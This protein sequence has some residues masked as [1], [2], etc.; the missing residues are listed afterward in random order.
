VQQ[1]DGDL[2]TLDIV[3]LC[4]DR[5]TGDDQGNR[6]GILC[7]WHDQH[8]TGDEGTSVWVAA[9]GR[10]PAFKCL[11]AH[12]QGRSLRDLLE[13]YGKEAVDAHCAEQFGD[14]S[15][16]LDERVN[17]IYSDYWA[18]H[19]RKPIEQKPRGDGR[20][21]YRASELRLL[22]KLDW[23]IERHYQTGGYCCIYG[24]PSSC[25]SFIALDQA[26]SIATGTP[27]LGKW[28]VRQAPVVYVCAEGQ[29]GIRHRIDAWCKHHG[30]AVPDTLIVIPHVF[31]L[32]RD[33]EVLALARIVEETM[34]G[35]PHPA[36]IYL[37]TLARMFPGGDENSTKDMN[38][39]VRN[40]A[41][42]GRAAHGAAVC[43]IHHTGKD[44]TRGARGSI[45]LEGACDTMLEVTGRAEEGAIKVRCHKQK[46]SSPLP[47]C[48]L[49]PTPVSLPDCEDGSLVLLPEHWLTSRLR[50]LTESQQKLYA[51]LAQ[52][53]GTFTYSEGLALYQATGKPSA[54]G[55]STYSDRLQSLV[56][57]SVVRK[58]GQGRYEVV[59][60]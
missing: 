48:C 25:K 54:A 11:H 26:L 8:T 41:A 55:K 27:Y 47:S 39:Y 3:A 56:Q 16:D 14:H 15:H 59:R 1:F 28:K 52:S 7:P 18:S 13:W 49:V 46:N 6:H 57:A 60:A 43:N 51:A 5:L 30:T 23:L 32:L 10:Y 42:L 53:L 40:T 34:V 12:C 33:D 21:G 4:D 2:R 24:A 44:S 20:R 38:A 37:D 36:A 9:D 50:G 19:E 22:P 35:M 17:E 29:E 45:A 58:D 31:C